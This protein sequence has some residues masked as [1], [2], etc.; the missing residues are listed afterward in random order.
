[1]S[2]APPVANVTPSDSTEQRTSTAALIEISLSRVSPIPLYHQLAQQLEQAVQS[3]VLAKGSFL[4][5]ELDLAEHWQVSRPTVRR[6]IQSLVDNGLLVRR[7]GVGTQ[8]VNDRVRRPFKLTS[9]YDDLVASGR[10]PSTVVLAHRRVEAE[11][12]TAEALAV[13]PGTE[14]VYFERCRSAG[15][16]RLAILRN[17]MT[18][19]VAGTI[20]SE[21]LTRTGLYELIRARGVRPHSALQQ[22]GAV[23]ASAADAAVLGLSAGAPLV[24][25][26]RV[27]QDDT[28]TPIEIG[29][30][31]YDAAHYVVEL[32][33]VES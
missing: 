24:T 4:D 11:A 17:W 23:A 20:T 16:Q 27:L 1:M 26:R 13:A 30:H 9:F 29:D 21:Q 3:G 2:Y 8:V 25:M 7:R 6:A 31:V 33:V 12:T 19:E 28:G 14:I 22:L 15:T 5:N 32:S 10:T 18:V